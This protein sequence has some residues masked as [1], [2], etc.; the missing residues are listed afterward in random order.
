ML[1]SLL[2]SNISIIAIIVFIV[3]FLFSIGF[4]EFSHAMSAHLLGDETPKYQGRLTLNPIAHLDPL[5]TFMIFF[6]PLGWG[7][8]V[9]VNPYNMGDKPEQKYFLTSIMGPIS[10][11]VLSAFFLLLYI[12][13]GY[14]NRSFSIPLS[15]IDLISINTV[16]KLLFILNI[17]LAIFN[18]IPIPP[19]D[20]SKI[21]AVILPYNAR[22]WFERYLN[23]YGFVLLIILILPILPGGGSI[24]SSFTGPIISFIT[25]KAF[26]LIK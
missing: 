21:W 12:L 26:A 4:H 13:W 23:Q 7:K 1:E 10:N 22:I 6:G 15:Y 11:I 17:G 14:L 2:A 16:L 3:A 20:G 19:L 8:P 25:D 18:L 24:L 5:G 9:E